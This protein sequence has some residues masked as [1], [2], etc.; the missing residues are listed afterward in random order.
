MTRL[1]QRRKATGRRVDNGTETPNTNPVSEV[2]SDELPLVTPVET[3]PVETTQTMSD[4]SD[5]TT[6]PLPETDAPDE[7]ATSERPP[8]QLNVAHGWVFWK[9]GRDNM[10][11][12]TGHIR[13][14]EANENGK[15]LIA[16]LMPEQRKYECTVREFGD[17]GWKDI[18]TFDIPQLAGQRYV[19]AWVT[20]P[21]ACFDGTKQDLRAK[22]RAWKG[23]ETYDGRASLRIT[24]PD[25]AKDSPT[26]SPV[27]M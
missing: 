27:P 25:L 4:T 7:Y 23:K 8:F 24:F 3:A 20:L 15:Q 9:V 14:T 12:F 19:E 22:V 1:V 13:F 16:R 6:A 10:H 26:H 18:V 11:V 2:K 21:A 17:K 5:P